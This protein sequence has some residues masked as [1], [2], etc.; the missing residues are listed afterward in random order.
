MQQ[1]DLGETPVHP[2]PFDPPKQAYLGAPLPPSTQNDDSKV[3]KD[4]TVVM[5][6]EISSFGT[7]HQLDRTIT[8]AVRSLKTAGFRVELL[9]VS[10]VE[11]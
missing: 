10:P 4:R 3:E 11:D 1:H 7:D 2:W 5:S 9:D 8:N 6:V